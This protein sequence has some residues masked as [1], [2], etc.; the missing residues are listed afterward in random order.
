MTDVGDRLLLVLIAATGLG[1]LLMWWGGFVEAEVEGTR[2]YVFGGFLLLIF[3]AALVL[4]WRS[5]Q[6]MD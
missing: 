6:Q 1:S 4:I 3:L 5:Y 2:A